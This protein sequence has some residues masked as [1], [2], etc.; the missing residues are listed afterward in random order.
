MFGILKM[1][2]LWV[3]NGLTHGP[4][5]RMKR[6][7]ER[8]ILRSTETEGGDAWRIAPLGTAGLGI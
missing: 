8:S 6:D 3:P 4:S 5:R 2:V 7:A 1:S